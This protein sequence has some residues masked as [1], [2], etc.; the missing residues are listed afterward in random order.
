MAT[1][2]PILNSGDSSNIANYGPINVLP[3]ISKVAE[4][5][6]AKTINEHLNKG[7]SLLHAMLF[8]F[9]ETHSTEFTNRLFKE[10]VKHTF[11]ILMLGLQ[12]NTTKTVCMM[13]SQQ[14]QDIKHAGVFL[15]GKQ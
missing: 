13:F 5:W 12:L 1:V 9:R 6:L 8:G 3:V 11:W 4:R 2:T 14:P 15:G 7:H 10:K